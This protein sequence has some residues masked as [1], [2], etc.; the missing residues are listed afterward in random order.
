MSIDDYAN[1][2]FNKL[3]DEEIVSTV[4]S[5]LSHA[6]D[7][8]EEW[9]I[10]GSNS[11]SFY[12][13]QQ[14]TR[15]DKEILS[16][17]GAPF[18]TFN[19]I[20]PQCNYLSGTQK[21]VR[22]DIKI[23]PIKGS[24]HT[25]AKILTVLI[26]HSMDK[27]YAQQKISEQ[28][29]DG[30]RTGKGWLKI[31]IDKSKD[32]LNGDIAVDKLDVFSVFEDP[33][34]TEYDLNESGKFIIEI[35]WEDKNKL[36]LQYPDKNLDSELANPNASSHR[37]N[38]NNIVK[39]SFGSI[40]DGSD[41]SS[42]TENRSEFRYK[43]I[44]CWVKNYEKRKHWI[45]NKNFTDKIITTKEEIKIAEKATENN[46]RFSLIDSVDI[47]MWKI[48]IVDNILLEKVRDP[49]KEENNDSGNQ[50]QPSVNSFPYFRYCFDFTEGRA[51]GLVDGLIDAQMEMNKLHSQILHHT[52]T[53]IASGY[54]YEE[55]SLSVDM[56]KIMA[57]NPR[58]GT[59]IEYLAGK[60]APVKISPNPL[61]TANV[62][63]EENSVLNI[64]RISGINK[65]NKGISSSNESGKLHELRTAQGITINNTSFDNLD[66]TIKIMGNFL[67]ELIRSTNV[68]SKEEIELIL[69]D[70]DLID[71]KSMQD[72]ANKVIKRFEVPNIKDVVAKTDPDLVRS[73]L[74]AQQSI[75]EIFNEE[76]KKE[77]KKTVLKR[78]KNIYKG[79]YGVTIAE[80]N[81]SDTI[82]Q[83]KVEEIVALEQLR[84]GVTPFPVLVE[85]LG[86]QDGERIIALVQ[87]REQQALEMA[88]ITA[89]VA[90]PP[91]QGL[92]S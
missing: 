18:L 46:K 32:V 71:I 14:W 41:S 78:V 42:R 25:E 17:S 5:F 33:N 30:T 88:Q 6:E 44:E 48:I 55:D 20:K 3:S 34:A 10:R 50:L 45:D 56:K 43:V 7:G 11:L 1:L 57:D 53:T 35:R 60:Q 75:Q 64:E 38:I 83:K 31:R 79:K 61:D 90:P 47:V 84:P 24:S 80:S 81:F 89:Q 70:E 65:S 69:D 63:L 51:E 62:Y 27:S 39:Y 59:H 26:K 72:A 73:S 67:H 13:G 66:Y 2:D 85:A 54:M 21:K 58:P 37:Q 92:S 68:Y 87:A 77:A 40:D 19:L 36:N 22:K 23:F 86:I 28:Y 91:G 8:L 16:A 12:R 4:H 82:K 49:F 74:N 29:S 52:N 9:R 76:V 15:E